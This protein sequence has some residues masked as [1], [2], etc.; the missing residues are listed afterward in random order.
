MKK[1]LLTTVTGTLL[2]A[3]GFVGAANATD[4]ADQMNV[5]SY[6]EH[7]VRDDDSKLEQFFEYEV[8]DE[9]MDDVEDYNVQVLENNSDKRVIML[10]DN[11][12]QY[13]SIFIKNTNRLKIID[14]DKGTIFNQVITAT[15]QLEFDDDD[16]EA[17]EN[18]SVVDID[19]FP[20]F[21]TLEEQ[22]NA[23]DD[24]AQIIED[25]QHKRVMRVSNEDSQ[26]QYKSIFIKETN[27]L[28]IID[29]HDKEVFNQLIKD[30]D[31]PEV[32][33]DDNE[34]EEANESTVEVDDLPEFD[35]LEEQINADDDHA[36]II[37]DNQHKRV[38]RVSNEDSQKQYKSI[39]IKE[40]NQLKIIDLQDKE[41]FNE[42][43]K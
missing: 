20:E 40:T 19:D 16:N 28:K 8:L 30:T 3:G 36:R 34:T 23:D 6:D 11:D 35:T 18:E 24:N 41:V 13:K 9:Y 43:I 38:M 26:K 2:L 42:I 31:Q 25:T 21:D 29:S 37:E 7:Q 22:I 27:Q 10:T 17:E 1:L 15:D 32:D 39:F 12:Q 14:L 5:N 4:T 33:D